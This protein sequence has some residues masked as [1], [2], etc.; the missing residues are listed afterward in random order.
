MKKEEEEEEAWMKDLME[1]KTYLPQLSHLPASPWNVHE[2]AQE[3]IN[4]VPNY[5]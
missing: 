1:R 2:H 4:K 5:H 3:K